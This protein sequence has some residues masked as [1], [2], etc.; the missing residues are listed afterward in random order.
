MKTLPQ[1]EL[2][3]MMLS[4]GT[5][6][7]T[8]SQEIKDNWHNI[9]REVENETNKQISEAGSITKWYESGVGRLI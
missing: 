8:D 7:E 2:E 6:K 5:Y 9:Y 1:K 4:T 3:D